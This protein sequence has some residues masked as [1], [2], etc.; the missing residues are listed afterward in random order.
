MCSSTF[1]FLAGEG[2]KGADGILSFLAETCVMGGWRISPHNPVSL[3]SG[4][5]PV[6]NMNTARKDVLIIAP[7]FPFVKRKWGYILGFFLKNF[8]VK[9]KMM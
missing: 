1:S 6:W 4:C 7:V 3:H 2:R 5:A 8:A 9:S